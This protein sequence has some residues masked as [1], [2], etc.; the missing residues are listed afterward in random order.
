MAAT[1]VAYFSEKQ[2]YATLVAAKLA[3][4][5][6]LKLLP[7]PSAA[8]ISYAGYH[9]E[10]KRAKTILIYD[11][12][13]GTFDISI[14]N[15][16]NADFNEIIKGGDMWLGGDDIDKILI[17]YIKTKTEKIYNIP[18][19]DD[20][21]DQMTNEK[22]RYLAK[23]GLKEEAEK[24]KIRLSSLQRT[25]F[26]FNDRIVDEN[27]DLL[28]IEYTIERDEFEKLIDPLVSRTV[29][30]VKDLIKKINY[31]YDMI[32]EFILVGGSSQIPLVQKKMK[33]EFGDRI[34]LSN[35]FMQEVAKGSAIIA[36]SIGQVD[37]TSDIVIPELRDI[38]I[39]HV[40]AHNIK[41]VIGEKDNIEEKLIFEAAQPFPAKKSI[42]V[43]TKYP[44]Q[45]IVEF[46][47]K[48]YGQNGEP[49]EDSSSLYLPLYKDYEAGKKIMFTFSL[50]E[51]GILSCNAQVEGEETAYK[52]IIDRG[53]GRTLANF[54]I[55]R[56][57]ETINKKNIKDHSLL[58]VYEDFIASSIARMS[59]FDPDGTRNDAKFYQ[60]SEDVQKLPDQIDEELASKRD[61]WDFEALLAY[62]EFLLD[63]YKP[64][65]KVTIEQDLTTI[66]YRIK[67]ALNGE[68]SEEDPQQLLSEINSILDRDQVLQYLDYIH[69]AMICADEISIKND[70]NKYYDKAFE[71]ARSE[72]VTE[73]DAIMKRA[74]PIANEVYKKL[75][76]PAKIFT[77]VTFNKRNKN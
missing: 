53:G 36:Q 9:S 30:L 63:R 77:D 18:S 47:I 19:L 28:Q 75:G 54:E 72:D 22:K 43:F 2:T 25:N 71:A 48:N 42:S 45:K 17:D 33:D 55:N 51:N 15:V 10:A 64:I 26:E 52:V 11:F 5:K 46:R 27:G 60:I 67:R 32:D 7:E 69:Y 61:G 35:T 59:N 20:L 76:Q 65:L 3:G 4:I 50:D 24:V 41:L 70:L 34:R 40:I 14:L 12:G 66:R 44:N 6:V 23:Y 62:V 49:L 74:F 16:I 29:Q 39:S 57:I 73:F 13:G 8:A 38:K 31:N 68:P 21:I 58:K 37:I 1:K 56:T